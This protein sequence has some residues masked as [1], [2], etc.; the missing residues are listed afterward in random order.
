M[1]FKRW[2]SE[3]YHVKDLYDHCNKTSKEKHQKAFESANQS[4]NKK[5]QKQKNKLDKQQLVSSST[6]PTLFFLFPPPKILYNTI[7]HRLK[8]LHSTEIKTKK[9]FSVSHK[10]TDP[11]TKTTKTKEKERIINMLYLLGEWWD[12]R[13]EW[14]D[15]NQNQD[16]FCRGS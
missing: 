14:C 8:H 4:S 12:E 11:D 9:T 6:N 10:D 3:D 2:V 5:I 7:F 15:I 13:R 16:Q 1:K